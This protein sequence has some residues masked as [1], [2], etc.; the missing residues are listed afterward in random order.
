M[1]LSRRVRWLHSVVLLIRAFG[2]GST[3]LFSQKDRAI[4]V[5]AL[6]QILTP[7][8]IKRRASEALCLH[9]MVLPTLLFDSLW[10]LRALV[11]RLDLL[12]TSPM[13]VSGLAHDGG[14][15]R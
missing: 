4:C 8:Q 7:M 2:K 1:P 13:Q 12:W 11:D 6:L 3:T 5:A 15:N 10:F 9:E 14:K